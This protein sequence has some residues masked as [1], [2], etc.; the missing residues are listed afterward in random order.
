MSLFSE[1]HVSKPEQPCIPMGALTEEHLGLSPVRPLLA[2]LIQRS[3]EEL[4][5]RVRGRATRLETEGM[6]T[7]ELC[8][9]KKVRALCQRKPEELY[10][11]RSCP[12]RL[13]FLH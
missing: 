13:L 5:R 3:H 11:D 12:S 8:S 6:A 2:D 4:T 1:I 9:W 10:E 7:A